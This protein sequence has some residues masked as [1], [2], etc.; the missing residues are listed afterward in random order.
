VLIAN[1]LK[2]RDQRDGDFRPSMRLARRG[3]KFRFSERLHDR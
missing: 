2:G 3:T 1:S